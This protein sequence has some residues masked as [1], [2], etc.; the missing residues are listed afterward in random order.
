M[1]DRHVALPDGPTVHHAQVTVD[2][3]VRCN[4]NLL[5]AVESRMATA[6][7]QGAL[8]LAAVSDATVLLWLGK[9]HYGLAWYKHEQQH[10]MTLTQ[11]GTADPRVRAAAEHARARGAGPPG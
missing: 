11:R 3:C 9:V 2:C 7:A 8:G 5:G 10:G 6:A 1:R 4:G